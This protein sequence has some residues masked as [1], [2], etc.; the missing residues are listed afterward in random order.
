MTLS[1]RRRRSGQLQPIHISLK[2]KLTSCR[3]AKSRRLR[4]LI[5]A[6]VERDMAARA[7]DVVRPVAAAPI[8]ARIPDRV[9]RVNDG[10]ARHRLVSS[11]VGRVDH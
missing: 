11:A 3:L 2:D 9:R 8:G 10:L 6:V 7:A 4:F 1:R 5:S